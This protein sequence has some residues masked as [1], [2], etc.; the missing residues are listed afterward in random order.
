MQTID[1]EVVIV[2]CGPV[3][4][5]M[6]NLLGLQGIRTLVIER[7]RAEHGEPRAFSCDDEGLRIYQMAGLVERLRADMVECDYLDYTGVDGRRF[8]EVLLDGVDFGSG[9]GAVNFFYQPRLERVLREGLERFEGVTLAL[10]QE[11]TALAQDATHVTL[12]VYDQLTCV[13]KQVRA[14]YVLGCDGARSTVRRLSGI[15]LEGTS[16]EEAWLAVSGFASEDALRLRHTRYV[17][18][19]RRPTF[20]GKGAAGDYRMEFMLLPGETAEQMERPGTVAALV[21]PYVDPQRL[22]ISRAVVYKFHNVAAQRWQ[23]GRVFLLGDAAHQMPPMMGQGLVSGLR[24][25]ANLSWKLA[26]VLHG[27]SDPAILA[28]YETE[29]RPHAQTMADISARVA[30]V[31]LT[32]RRWQALARDQF[33]INIQ[34]IPRV[35]RFFQRLEFKP[36]ALY[37]KGLIMGGKRR[38]RKAVEGTLFPQ[39]RV[40]ASD[41]SSVMLDDLLGAGFAVISMGL[42]PREII[43]QRDDVWSRLGTRLVQ[44]LP[45]GASVP[46]SASD[47]TQIVDTT[48]RLEA[49]FKRHNA[50]VAV[51]RPDRFVFATGPREQSHQIARSLAETFPQLPPTPMS[52][53]PSETPLP[54]LAQ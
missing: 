17:C 6:A 30:S 19:P 27:S 14:R 5:L 32:R 38:H 41:G 44:I 18:D 53:M 54:V 8:A 7:E 37:Q 35:R 12:T 49:W 26:L 11:V 3:G 4:A 36:R 10:G 20:V 9:Y 50:Q 29:R 33:F 31:F 43:S 22:D 39:V 13:T 25:A 48:G 45:S 51:V 16:Y 28:S 46:A 24:D 52:R 2:G 34:R 1:T 42:D 21:A 23:A 15:E 40:V 47:V